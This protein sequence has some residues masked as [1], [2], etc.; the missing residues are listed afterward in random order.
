MRISTIQ[1]AAGMALVLGAAGAVATSASRVAA[2]E[3]PVSYAADQAARGEAKYLSECEECHGDDLKG[4]LN[5]GAS[6]AGNAF[7]EKW[8]EGMQASALFAYLANE[9]PPDNAGRYSPKAYAEIMAYI[10][11]RNGYP[12]GA[13]LPSDIDALDALIMQR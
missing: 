10:L 5:G 12:E 3:R 11:M 7:N 4:G 6:L 8:G 13:E 2:S 9:M 1:W